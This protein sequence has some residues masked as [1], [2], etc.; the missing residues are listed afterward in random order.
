MQVFKFFFSIKWVLTL[1]EEVML[2][3]LHR[4]NIQGHGSVCLTILTS[5]FKS[6]EFGNRIHQIINS[7][8][9]K[10]HT[11]NENRKDNLKVINSSLWSKVVFYGD[12]G[13]HVNYKEFHTVVRKF[14]VKNIIPGVFKVARL[15]TLKLK[16]NCFDPT[17]YRLAY[18][19]W[20][21]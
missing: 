5:A 12:G 13:L 1:T 20:N 15:I 6:P 7:R 17:F 9:G 4:L 3:Y 2:K 10:N 18:N 21:H 19:V 8:T 11:S 16:F 14:T